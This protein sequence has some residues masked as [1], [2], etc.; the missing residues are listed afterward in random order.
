MDR[1][2]NL[3]IIEL[4]V[5]HESNTAANATRKAKK[6]E[7]LLNDGDLKRSYRKICFV[8]LVMT[9]IGIYSKHSEEFFKVLTDL[10]I[11]NIAASYISTK[12]TEI[13]IRSS[14]YI[15]C[16]RTKEWTELDLMNF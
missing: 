11:D 13:C 3:F 16:M 14:Y 12:L 7:H 1:M 4:T 2:N 10:N 8:N 5:G 9:A 6:Y 15:F